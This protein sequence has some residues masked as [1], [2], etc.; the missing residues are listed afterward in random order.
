[1]YI[2]LLLTPRTTSL[3]K[4]PKHQWENK[5]KITLMIFKVLLVKKKVKVLN[6]GEKNSFKIDVVLLN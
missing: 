6:E 4:N 1:M 3:V 5:L 2:I